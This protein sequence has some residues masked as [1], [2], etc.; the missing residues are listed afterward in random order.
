MKESKTVVAGLC[1]SD[2]LGVAFIIMKLCGLITWSWT[3]VLA[4]IWIPIAV[5]AILIIFLVI[6]FK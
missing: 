1:F 3:W 4:P 2:L 6:I 5:Y